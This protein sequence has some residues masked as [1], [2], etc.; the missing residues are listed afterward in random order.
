MNIKLLYPQSREIF[1]LTAFLF[2]EHIEI[3]NLDYDIDI[4]ITPNFNSYELGLV[5][6]LQKSIYGL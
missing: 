2:D 3:K 4:D 1:I 5:C 6:K